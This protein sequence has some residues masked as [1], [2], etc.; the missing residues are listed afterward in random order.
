[1]PEVSVIEWICLG[2]LAVVILF[3]LSIRASLARVESRLNHHIK[4]SEAAGKA[5]SPATDAEANSSAFEQ[6]LAE[7][8]ER[9]GLSKTEQFA[10]Y[11]E[12]RKDKGLNWSNS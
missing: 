11:R 5:S 2:L 8:P 6:F 4:A 12:W 1:M 10:A 3:L 9:I 7:D